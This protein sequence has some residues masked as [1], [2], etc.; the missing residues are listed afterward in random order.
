MV[1][2]CRL[3]PPVA[4]PTWISILTLLIDKYI[5]IA[6]LYLLIAIES[7]ELHALRLNNIDRSVRKCYGCTK[8]I[9]YLQDV[10]LS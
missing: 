4:C 5:R 10:K 7:I 9:S 6:A 8:M 2:R 1:S 3:I